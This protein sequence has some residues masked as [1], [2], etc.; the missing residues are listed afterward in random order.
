[1]HSLL[2][3]W[4]VCMNC[5]YLSWEWGNLERMRSLYIINPPYASLLPCGPQEKHFRKGYF[6]IYIP[7]VKTGKWS[8]DIVWG[9]ACS[10]IVEG[11]KIWDTTGWKTK[12][13]FIK[14]TIFKGGWE[15]GEEQKKTYTQCI[16]LL[17]SIA[18]VWYHRCEISHMRALLF[19][20]WRNIFF[21]TVKTAGEKTPVLFSCNKSVGHTAL[22]HRACSACK[23]ISFKAWR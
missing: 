10:F 8:T 6:I 3:F 11:K 13:R 16:F 17:P 9:T 12:L 14:S 2:Q 19:F 7:I 21:R 4:T 18:S 20:T 22:V 1:M 15:Q 23:Q 5:I